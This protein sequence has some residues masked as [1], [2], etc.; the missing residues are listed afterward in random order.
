[1]KDSKELDVVGFMKLLCESEPG[2][3]VNIV[4][5]MYDR[6]PEDEKINDNDKVQCL[7]NHYSI[8]LIK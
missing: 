5:E 2:I 7:A 6:L 3:V 1:M 8:A 4:N